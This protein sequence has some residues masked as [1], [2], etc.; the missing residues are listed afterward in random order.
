[1][2]VTPWNLSHSP[3]EPIHTLK[4]LEFSNDYAKTAQF[5]KYWWAEWRDQIAFMLQKVNQAFIKEKNVHSSDVITNLNLN[6]DLL[7]D[8]FILNS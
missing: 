3:E 6:S 8:Y 2:L 1:M 4:T 5:N 7:A